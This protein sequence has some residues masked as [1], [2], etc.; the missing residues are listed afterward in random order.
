M[1]C[2]TFQ[3]PAMLPSPHEEQ[4]VLQHGLYWF[5]GA[6]Y[7]GRDDQAGR[8]LTE[9][10][11]DIRTP[12][13][14]IDNVSRHHAWARGADRDQGNL[15]SQ[16]RAAIRKPRSNGFRYADQG[17]RCDLR[18]MHLS[19]QALYRRGVSRHWRGSRNVSR[20]RPRRPGRVASVEPWPISTSRQP[21]LGSLSPRTHASTRMPKLP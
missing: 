2:L 8:F 19:Q 13:L 18:P 6:S 3:W 17:H 12:S 20:S 14:V 21:V 11:W 4:E 16:E 1:G 9:G 5:V 7:G 10:I 15:R